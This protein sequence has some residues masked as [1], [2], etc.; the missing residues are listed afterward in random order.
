MAF[1]VSYIY[2]ILDKYSAPLKKIT[3][4][5]NRFHKSADQ[6]SQKLRN[7]SGKMLSV[8][9]AVTSF[10]GVLGGANVLGTFL[11]FDKAMNKL[12]SVTLEN[13]EVMSQFRN[14]AKKL[15]ETTQFTA[16]QAAE[17]M[18]FLA[19]AGL[20]TDQVLSAIP[21]TLKLAAAGGLDLAS[22]ADIATNVMAQ[23]GFSASELTRINDVL[24]LSQSKANLNITEM[25]E[26]MR[27][28]AVTAKNLGFSL[29]ETASLMSVMANAGEKGSIAGTLVRNMLTNMAGPS[30]SQAK[31][32]R[33]LGINMKEFTTETGK[34]KN[35]SGFISKL[36]ELDKSGKATVPVLQAMFG[37][38]GFRAAQIFIGAGG[39]EL[40]RFNK[41]YAAAGG[42]ADKASAAMMRGLPGVV[43]AMQS[44]FEAAKIAL[45]ESGIDKL[46][47]DIFKQITTFMRDLAST[48]PAVLKVVG[49]IGMIAVVAGPVL[50]AIGM[51]ANGIAAI[52]TIVGIISVPVVVVFAAV[53]AAITAV[54]VV[55]KKAWDSSEKFRSGVSRFINAF[56][57]LGDVVSMIL[58]P[59]LY[60]FNE[61]ID[62]IQEFLPSFE[63]IGDAIGGA[64]DFAAR[65]VEMGVGEI[66]N[67]FGL[68]PAAES[69]GM[70]GTI[71]GRIEV[72][73][74]GGSRV[75]KASLNTNLPGNMGMNLAAP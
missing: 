65:G 13:D 50:I 67:L 55:L 9:S 73:A 32:Y 54:V 70:K 4:Q 6:A 17:G 16:G 63:Q 35:F 52:A 10:A 30:K 20:N 2:Q 26:A 11:D 34:I 23:M 36:K 14:T 24:A 12:A 56:K 58:E 51:I 49:I 66:R 42:T 62:A 31:L 1:S 41:L 29:E 19:M 8:Q 38:R 68:S 37:D 72:A 53:A 48:S 61:L 69:A 5:T 59:M 44:A 7:F 46:L 18:T 74:S 3:N 33:R 39:D 64:F 21:Q 25:F 22:A 47:I 28:A 71:D 75:T 15:G 57:P 43:L 45:V 27:P 60:L 40:A